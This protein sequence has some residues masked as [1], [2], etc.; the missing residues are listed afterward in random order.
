MIAGCKSELAAEESQSSAFYRMIKKLNGKEKIISLYLKGYKIPDGIFMKE[1][2][3]KQFLPFT[4]EP[5]AS[6]ASTSTQ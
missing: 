6:Q 5:H 3:E 1:M 2:L 4:P